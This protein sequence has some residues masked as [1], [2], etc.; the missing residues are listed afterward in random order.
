MKRIILV[1]ALMAF[2]CKD[3]PVENKNIK[4]IEMDS[5]L[6]VVINAK[7]LENDKFEVYFSEDILNQYHVE[8][9]IE[10]H[11]I[12][13]T[14]F[15]DISFQLP[16]R[17]Y[18]IK[19]RIDIGSSEVESP[20]EIRKITLSTTAK[21]KSFEGP[22]LN[23]FFKTNKFIE[24]EESNNIYNRI[25]IDGVYD[26]FMVTININDIVTNLFNEDNVE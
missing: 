1:L 2:S 25:S 11:V 13:D 18:P 10:K 22:E 6:T 15:Q 12:G 14:E 26:P 19:L 16:E 5:Y 4:S 7:V 17:I 3:K 24:H 9:K 8:D 23:T 20:I 21:S